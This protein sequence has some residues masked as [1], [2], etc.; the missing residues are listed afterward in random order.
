MGCGESALLFVYG[1]EV[2]SKLWMKRWALHLYLSTLFR[3]EE[4]EQDEAG[5]L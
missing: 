4:L 3:G 2:F 5:L 1:V